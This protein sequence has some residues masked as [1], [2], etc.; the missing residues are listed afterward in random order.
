MARSS[1]IKTL[2]DAVT[3]VCVIADDA[4]FT[5]LLL[6]GYSA[7]RAYK[8]AYRSAATM[9]SCAAMASRRLRDT[10]IQFALKAAAGLAFNDLISMRC[11]LLLDDDC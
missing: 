7:A 10:D 9:A 4:L 2:H 1:K 6:A 8:I 3:S 11:G 5:V